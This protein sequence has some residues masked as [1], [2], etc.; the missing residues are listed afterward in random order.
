[1]Q[2]LSQSR[3]DYSLKELDENE[4]NPNP[5]VQFRYWLDEAIKTNSM[6]E[7]NAMTFSTVSPEGRPSSRIVLLKHISDDG[8]D[9]FTNYNS[10][11]GKHLLHNKY[12]SLLFFWPALEREVRIEGKVEKISSNISDE[13]FTSRP[14]ESQIAAWASPQSDIVPNRSTLMDWYK[15]F[16]SIFESK[17]ITRPP[18]WGGYRLVP[19]LVEFWQGRTNRLHDRVE[20]ILNGDEWSLRRLAP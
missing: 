1:M 10:K 13:Y 19:D 9:F 20:Y 16:E 5:I 2:D 14:F 3:K 8:F 4:L 12:A 17:D 18:H 6:H 11:K 7:P 15:E